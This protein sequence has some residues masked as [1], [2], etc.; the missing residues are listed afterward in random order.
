LSTFLI[1]MIS[2]T[3]LILDIKNLISMR[4]GNME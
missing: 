4:K 3:S 2:I 1:E